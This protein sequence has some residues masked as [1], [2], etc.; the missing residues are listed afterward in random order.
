[1]AIT[2]MIGT[3]ISHYLIE[4]KLGAGGMGEVYLAH[5]CKLDRAVALK[6]MPAE[7]VSNPERLA[8]FMREAK[9]ASSVSH[10]NVAHIYE[11][12]E[13]NHRKTS[14]ILCLRAD[15]PAR[16]KKS[17]KLYWTGWINIW[18]R[19]GKMWCGRLVRR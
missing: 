18:E 3:T 11:I 4:K 1:M 19:P 6:I 8:R 5:D 14:S 15:I 17:L 12:G 10:P 9:A 2:P 13:E 7:F 16:A